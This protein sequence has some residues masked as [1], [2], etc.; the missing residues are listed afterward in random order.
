MGLLDSYR[1]YYQT[2]TVSKPK[3]CLGVPGKKHAV[4]KSE[5]VAN[6]NIGWG[7]GGHSFVAT[8]LPVLI[9][10]T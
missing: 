5:I 9:S 8:D 4:K 6:E 3:I 2:V 10:G 1:I 7:G